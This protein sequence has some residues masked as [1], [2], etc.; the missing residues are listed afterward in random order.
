MPPDYAV[1]C[2]RIL[3]SDDY[4]PALT[5]P[6]VELVTD[7]ISRVTDRSILTE[8]GA[9]RDVDA[10][11][12]GTGFAPSEPEFARRIRG[13]DGATLS[14]ANMF[15]VL[16][17]NTGLG[18][19]SAL[20][21]I[22]SCAAYIADAMDWMQAQGVGVVDVRPEEQARY[23][24]EIQRRLSRSVWQTGGCRS[25][26]QDANGRNTALWP[27]FAFRYRQT[28]AHFRPTAYET[29][30]ARAPVDAVPV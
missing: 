27:G 21:I 11:V 6:N 5:Q 12:F 28:T 26:Y 14:A 24:A 1:G 4:Y 2:K 23:N 16:G 22:E 18:H 3:L 20:D 10:I 30:P 29:R 8:D 25:W 17:P 13:R 15:L 7:R 19:N 9:E